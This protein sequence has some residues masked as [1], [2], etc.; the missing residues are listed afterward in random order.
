MSH[1]TKTHGGS[2]DSIKWA[3]VFALLALGLIGNHQ[4][5]EQSFLIRLI[6]FLGLTFAAGVIAVKTNKGQQFW[7]FT[8]AARNELR[9]V[10]WPSRKETVQTAVMVLAIV[11]IVGLILW[12]IDALLLKFVA[13]IIGY[14]AQ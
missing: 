6:A 14:G 13:F 7:Q 9:K 8:L 2:M 10:V 4:F 5:A 11:G 1:Q 3:V 12:G